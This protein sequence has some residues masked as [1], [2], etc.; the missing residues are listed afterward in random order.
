MGQVPEALQV[1]GFLITR[2]IASGNANAP[3]IIIGQTA[4]HLVLTSGD[5]AL[6]CVKA[7]AFGVDPAMP[8]DLQPI[9]RHLIVEFSGASRL[10]DA[11]SI[12]DALCRAAV[13]AGAAVL[14]TRMHD[15]GTHHGVTGVVLLAESHIS[16]HTWP[17]HGYA[18]I[19]IFM[20]GAAEPERAVAVLAAFFRPE[21][22]EVRCLERGFAGR[23]PV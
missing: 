19:D 12:S 5:R 3:P 6:A 23:L 1:W 14:E 22:R 7:V 15:F 16:I 10:T 20:C 13:A 4:V 18:A 9:G 8:T 21:R 2:E 11:A 17:E